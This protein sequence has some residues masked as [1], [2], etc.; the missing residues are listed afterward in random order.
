M[1]RAQQA[2]HQQ[3]QAAAQSSGAAQKAQQVYQQQFEQ[4]RGAEER[5]RGCVCVRERTTR[6]E[7]KAVTAR[8]PALT[9]VAISLSLSRR[10]GSRRWR[11]RRTP[12]PPSTTQGEHE[13]RALGE[14][15]RRESRRENT[16]GDHEGEGRV[17]RMEAL[18]EGM[19]GGG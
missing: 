4:V 3:A 12:Q 11:R 9:R 10:R 14:S 17:C 16:R 7:G 2:Q 8:E 6:R 5:A 1:Y 15:A 19:E 13:E 18:C